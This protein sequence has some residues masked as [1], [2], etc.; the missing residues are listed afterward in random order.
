MDLIKGNV[1]DMAY[2]SSRFD[3]IRVWFNNKG[4]AASVS[5]MNAI[6]NV[7]LRAGMAAKA[8]DFDAN[9]DDGFI[10]PNKYGIAAI[11]HPMNFTKQQLDKEVIRQI[12]ISLLHAICIVFA[13]SFVPAS[14]VV[15]HIDEKVTKVRH[16]HFVSGVKPWTYWISAFLW[17]FC[18]YTITALLCIFIFV[19]FD[20]K[21]YVSDENFPGL[22]M[23]MFL[24]GWSAIP[25]MYPTSFL[26]SVPSSAFV[27]LACAN[28]FVGIITTVTTFVLENF[29]DEELR[30]IGS[31]L[32][33]VFLIFPHYCLGRGLM[34]MAT[35]M[36]LNLI[37]DRF[38]LISVRNRFSWGFLGKYMV[39]MGIQ[40]FAFFALTMIVQTKAWRRF[41]RRNESPAISSFSSISPEDDEDID[42]KAE[43]DRIMRSPT[44]STNSNGDVLQVKGLAKRYA[45]KE[46]LA[47]DRLTFGVKKGECFGLL[48]VNGAGKTTTFKM[49][50]GELPN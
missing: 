44:I 48:G 26:F 31:I 27:T 18:M 43:R 49:L 20:A 34:D 40:G 36:N 33:E 46:T 47:V 17:D 45:G 32:K 15:F 42:V 22:L 35:E 12:G 19:A 6:N 3:N 50:T 21:A 23:L 39:S 29:D 16:L 38:G 30:F 10:D 41:W 14:F 8:D 4:W 37:L 9:W 7:I 25:L 28:L 13:M 1:E 2:S 24:Y 5:Y 11:N